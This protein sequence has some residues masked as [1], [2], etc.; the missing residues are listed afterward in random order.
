[1]SITPGRL[2]KQY[3][4]AIA[5]GLRTNLVPR[6][7]NRDATVFSKSKKIRD[8]VANRL[9]WVDSAQL[10]ARRVNQIKTFG[11][12]VFAAKFRHVLLM[13]MGG[14]SLCPE[15]F[16]R[17]HK[18]HP[19]LKSFDVIDSTDPAAV[20]AIT[21]KLELKKTLFIV[22]SKS[23]GTIETRSHEAFFLYQL[24]ELGV[25]QPGRQ[26]VAITDEGS[27][28]Q[29]DARRLKYRKVFVNP[30]DI[31]GRFSAMS[32]FGLVPGLFAGADID[33][34]ASKALGMQEMM[35]ER[36]G[37]SNPALQLG[38][39]MSAAAQ[40]GIDKLTFVA[41]KRTA[42]L[43]PWIEQLVAESTGKQGK[44]LVP[45][46]AEPP[47]KTSEYGK[48]RLIVS[49]RMASER[50]TEQQKFVAKMIAQRSPVVQMTLEGPADL[51][52]QFLLWEGATAVAGQQLKINPFD[53]PNV[54]ESKENT[55]KILEAFERSG[56]FPDEQAKKSWGGLELIAF[57]GPQ[58][59][60]AAT[61]E[62]PNQTL[63]RF[64]ASA[65]PPKFVALLG[66]FKSDPATE[67]AFEE[68]RKRI[69]SELGV[70][71]LRGYGPRFLHSIGQLYKGGP[72]NGLY[73]VFVRS[74]YSRLPIPG[75]VFDFGQLIA[76]QAMGD[77]QAL[78][79]RDLPTLVIGV[80]KQP[81]SGLAE[82]LSV[83]NRAI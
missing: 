30:S 50:A 8:L 64:L 56:Q 15:V 68:I 75:K 29:L 20:S 34:L 79:K 60:G 45:V 78:I 26:F 36:E 22:A 9:G 62:S 23:G 4:S 43:V 14:S 67:R 49:V 13:G 19:R 40:N 52:K 71:T 18:C 35:A 44:G 82:F 6:I 53:E 63:E 48:D 66:Y 37:E 51:G 3:D 70:A 1:M 31:G 65:K 46:E 17:I 32:F 76:A 2:G 81:A 83:L 5:A 39:I 77:S 69:R 38:A 59:M 72:Q 58:R 27:A 54:T 41:S 12:A 24:R 74:K 7:M 28:L 11:N 25:S 21:R 47:G 80:N 33:A 10:M 73:I 57:G 61:L 16:K 55:R 42:P